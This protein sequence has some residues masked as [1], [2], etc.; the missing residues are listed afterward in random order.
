MSWMKFAFVATPF[1]VQETT[2]GIKRIDE[3]RHTMMKTMTKKS[4]RGE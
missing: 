3:R 2:D 4:Y 1:T